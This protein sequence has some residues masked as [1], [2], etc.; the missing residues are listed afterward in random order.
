MAAFALVSTAA[1]GGMTG[2]PAPGD[3][4]RGEPLYRQ[5]CAVCHGVTGEGD[6]PNADALEEDK[7]RDLTDARYMG[8]LADRQLAEVIRGGGAAAGRSRFM[9]AW[10]S[11]FSAGQIADLVAH[12]REIPR[13]RP[14]APATADP[15]VADGG[16]LVP[17]LGCP[18]CH[19]IGDLPAAPVAP[20]LSQAGEKLQAAW[21]ARFL[22]DPQAIDARS[23][24]PR[25]G[26]GAAEASAI[27]AY[28]LGSR[29]AG[30]T[31]AA[32]DH[33][34]SRG[35]ALFH[36]LACRACHRKPEE[37]APG[38][39]GPDLTFVGDKLRPEWL[40]G[41]LR[42]PHPVRPWLR[43]RMPT[44][45]LTD[46]EIEQVTAFLAS[47]RDAGLRA[48]PLRLQAPASPSPDSARAGARLASRDYLSCSSCHLGGDRPPEGSPE[49]WAPDLRLAGRRLRPE[50]IVRWLRDPQRV[51]PG[52]K[53]PSFFA[54]ADSGLRDLLDGDRDR[55]ILAVRD[56]LLAIGSTPSRAAP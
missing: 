39:V 23:P 1:V 33:D 27:A 51:L 8:R 45:G 26:I 41:Y 7:P 36:D 13:P 3:P 47:L 50:W 55:Q 22:A 31:A 43:A 5:Y 34:L 44:F 29:A 38:R 35:A 17:E 4:T 19:R 11:T 42:Q 16:R 32:T 52:T 25:P 54:D 48:L 14:T 49:E 21:V 9:P 2:D 20:D 40:A 28:L 6:G 24:M 12:L 46:A 15:K 56:Y 30:A 10:G 53:M 37:E 18:G